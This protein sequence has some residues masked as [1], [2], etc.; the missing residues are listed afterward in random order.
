MK[1]VKYTFSLIHS[2]LENTS[3]KFC[4]EKKEWKYINMWPYFTYL[5]NI[6][7]HI[8]SMGI[9]FKILQIDIFNFKN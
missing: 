2:Y 3:R 7:V 1:L 4:K 9:L 8:D 6:V 5:Q